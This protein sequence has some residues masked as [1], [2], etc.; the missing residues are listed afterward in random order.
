MNEL[1]KKIYET[2]LLEEAQTIHLRKQI[3]DDVAQRITS[4]KQNINDLDWEGLESDVYASCH[5]A[6]LVGFELG[7]KFMKRLW[8]D[9]CC[10]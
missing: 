8:G 1:V 7:I 2:I 5:I 3:D 9:D 10:D 6:E 4:F